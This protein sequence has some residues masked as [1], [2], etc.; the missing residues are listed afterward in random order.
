MRAGSAA[1]AARPRRRG[2]TGPEHSW[3]DRGRRPA[4][5][6]RQ[7]EDGAAAFSRAR[8]EIPAVG[9]G[10]RAGDGKAEARE[11]LEDLLLAALDSRTAVRDLDDDRL[12]FPTRLDVDLPA[13]APMLRGVVE[14]VDQ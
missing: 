1:C 14:E 11:A 9:A 4:D 6:E 8:H 2:P 3:C 7:E 10:D 12:A 13:A 5:R